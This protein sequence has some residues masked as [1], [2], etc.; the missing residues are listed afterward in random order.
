M[1][2]LWKG[3]I[4]LSPGFG[5]FKGRTG[6][7]TL[8]KHSA[9]QLT[10]PLSKDVVSVNDG[11]N[12]H[13]F[14][15]V[16]I[17]P[18]CLHMITGENLLSIYVDPATFVGQRLKS[19]FDVVQPIELDDDMSMCLKR[20]SKDVESLEQILFQF[21]QSFTSQPQ[22]GPAPRLKQVLRVLDSDVSDCNVTP[23]SEIAKLTGL[24]PSRFSHWFKQ[25]TGISLR[26]YRKWLLL[27][28]GINTLLKAKDISIA[29]SVNFSDQPHF[30]R[31]LKSTFGLT[32]KQLLDGITVFGDV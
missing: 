29:A 27:I 3:V 30:S 31:T 13:S 25:Q 18:N 16:L 19:R 11:V 6:D 2:L 22:T 26:S 1:S 24:S 15:S 28:S 12:N 10:L 7:N 17:P 8:H 14:T 5:I 9:Y 20:L 32:P 21:I 23:V 4:A